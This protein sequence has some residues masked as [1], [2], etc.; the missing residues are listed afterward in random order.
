LMCQIPAQ[1]SKHWRGAL[2]SSDASLWRVDASE[3]AA[4]LA[5]SSHQ[6]RP[7]R[8]SRVSA[9]S[10][11]PLTARLTRAI[12][13]PSSFGGPRPF[14]SSRGRVMG[15]APGGYC[16]C[17]GYRGIPEHLLLGLSSAHLQPRGESTTQATEKTLTR[18][19]LVRRT[20]TETAKDQKTSS[21]APASEERKYAHVSSAHFHVEQ[22]DNGQ[23]TAYC[24]RY[25]RQGGDQ[26][27]LC[28]LK[29]HSGC[30]P[31]P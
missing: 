16:R 7:C 31:P 19:R 25:P 22:E 1:E 21:Q 30:W 3:T 12:G 13:G 5:V 14:A 20:M 6:L 27:S 8:V 4:S 10:H 2:Q 29:R 18:R 15:R 17:S 11:G 24:P 9:S 26:L 23:R 28:L